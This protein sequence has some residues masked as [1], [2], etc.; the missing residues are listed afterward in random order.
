MLRRKPRV[1][2]EQRSFVSA[3]TDCVHLRK[4]AQPRILTPYPESSNFS[5][6]PRSAYLEQAQTYNQAT[7]HV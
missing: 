1:Q 4:N 2:P 5:V 6:D 7:L 3:S